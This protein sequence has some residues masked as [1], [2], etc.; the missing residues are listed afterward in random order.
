[1]PDPKADPR[2]QI[3][4][5]G[6]DGAL[7]PLDGIDGAYIR[8]LGIGEMDRVNKDSDGGPYLMFALAVC[9]GDG[10]ALFSETDVP[11][12]VKIKPEPFNRMMAQVMCVNGMG[13]EA[14]EATEG[15]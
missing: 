6:E 10:K 7:V 8:P 14:G 13:D 11:A 2:A 9:D 3:L 5:M 12:I 4:A 1:M 15:N